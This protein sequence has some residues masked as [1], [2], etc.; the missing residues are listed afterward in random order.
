V[1]RPIPRRAAA[2][3]ATLGCLLAIVV[4]ACSGPSSAAG[5]PVATS[6]VDLPPS[7]KFAPADIS[8]AAGTTV[9][10][11]NDDHFTHSVHFLGGGLPSTP[12]V[13]QPGDHTTFTFTT[14]GRY[15]YECH[16]HP[17]DMRGTVTVGG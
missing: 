3:L 12:M 1:R 5:A 17:Q 4:T 15:E 14:P 7:Y 9:T 10:W 16:L 13:M 8:V 11:T 6:T 2:T